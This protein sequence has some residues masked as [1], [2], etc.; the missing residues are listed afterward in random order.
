MKS[1]NWSRRSVL[2]CV[3]ISL[4]AGASAAAQSD[5]KKTPAIALIDAADAPQWQTWVKAR[6]WQVLTGSAAATAPIDQRVLA[7]T[8]AVKQAIANG[9]VDPAHIYIGGRGDAAAAVF[10]TISRTPDLWAAGVALGGSPQPAVDTDRIYSANFALT[11][12]LWVSA[13]AGDQALADKLKT[14]GLNLE[15]RAATGATPDEMLDW[16]IKHARED[17]PREIGC[18]TNSPAFASCYWIRMTKFDAA[19]RN[20]VLA[21]T[22]IPASSG[23]ALDLGGFGFKPDDPGPGVT[24][25]Y[26]PEKYNGPLKM[27]DRIVALDGREIANARQYMDLMAKFVEEKQAVVMVQRGKDRMRV[28]TRVVL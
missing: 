16:L 19:E 28:E 9:T 11:P 2:A 15:W 23:A 4:L 25:S 21:P 1:K 5:A 8:A 7:L 13:G 10:Y 14:A 18:E 26:L 22:R 3:T 6:G 27:G 24:V 20:D 12:V 17:F